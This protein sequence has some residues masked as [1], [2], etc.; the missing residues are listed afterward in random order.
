MPRQGV[1]AGPFPGEQRGR[2]R[3]LNGP[4]PGNL[5]L[6]RLQGRHGRG[7][8]AGHGEHHQRNPQE[9]FHA[10][11]MPA[12]ASVDEIDKHVR[13]IGENDYPMNVHHLELF[14]YVA[15]HG[16][17]SPAVRQMPYGIQQPAISGQ[18]L[19]L[20]ESIG[21]KL[22]HRRP[23]TLTPA[24][25]R[26]YQ[27]I[28]PFFA[29][30]HEVSGEL[31]GQASQRLRLAASTEVLRDH[32]PTLIRQL[33]EKHP[34]LSL[35]LREAGQAT[36]EPLLLRGEIDLAITEVDDSPASGLQSVVLARLPLVLWVPE[37]SPIK[38]V[39]ALFTRGTEISE[40]LICLPAHET[41]M[42][43]FREGL[44]SLGQAWEPALEVSSIDLIETYVAG[45]FGV[46]LSV[47]IPGRPPLAGVRA[48]P[49]PGFAP[50]V[51]A[52]LWTGKLPA[53]P[54]A[55]LDLVKAR[56]SMLRNVK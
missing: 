39:K 53:V 36:A 1:R 42:R 40:S 29:N 35:S 7:G 19:K 47:A 31:R 37:K 21:G 18:I 46:G 8:Q 6:L 43:R 34:L 54:M 22:F 10:A 51:V 30:L 44:R 17:I 49:L 32:V 3:Q 28:A 24:G 52:A 15:K 13:R 38:N 20:E 45:G 50:V 25:D 14:Y 16:G 56:A 23:F 12:L 26:L 2:F 4:R 5:A 9:R 11:M 33:R 48:V 27:F 55:F 41:V